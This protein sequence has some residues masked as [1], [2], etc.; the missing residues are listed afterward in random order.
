MWLPW[1]LMR[2]I[3]STSTA[4]TSTPSCAPRYQKKKYSHAKLH[5]DAQIKTSMGC[6]F[7]TLIQ[8]EIL[9]GSKGNPLDF[10]LIRFL[11]LALPRVSRV[12]K[13]PLLLPM[14]QR[15]KI[16]NCLHLRKHSPSQLPPGSRLAKIHERNR[17]STLKVGMGE[18][19]EP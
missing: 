10:S 4:F 2:G 3:A 9:E 13:G 19:E 1:L 7:K 8:S 18:W 11:S 5:P 17:R 15:T 6:L 12:H 14:A 16:G